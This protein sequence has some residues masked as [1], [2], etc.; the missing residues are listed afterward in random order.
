MQY[1]AT[2]D[3]SNEAAIAAQHNSNGKLQARI[4]RKAATH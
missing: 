2:S 4:L 1:K 3:D